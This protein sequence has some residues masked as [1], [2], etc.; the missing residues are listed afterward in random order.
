MLQGVNEAAMRQMAESLDIPGSLRRVSTTEDIRKLRHF[1]SVGMKE[2][3][4]EKRS[5]LAT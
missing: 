3:S 2:R 1:E 4:S 5:T